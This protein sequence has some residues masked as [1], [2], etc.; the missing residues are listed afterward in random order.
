[1]TDYPEL[2]F[3]FFLL[4]A[5]FTI[6]FTSCNRA[7]EDSADRYVVMVSLDGFRYDYPDLYATPVL[8]SVEKAGVRAVSLQPS[9]P[10]KT[11]PNHYTIATGLYPDHHG[12]VLNNFF[13]PESG[14]TY[15]IGNRQRVEDPYFY[16][17]EPVWVT[18]EKQGIKAAS[19]YWVGSETSVE[20]IY[21]TYWK[22][23]DHQFPY[24]QRIDTVIAWL[25][26]PP[27]KRPHLITWY[28]DQPD[29]WGHHTGPENPEIGPLISGLDSLLGYFF[30]K[31]RNLPV[32]HETDVIITSDHG[33][34]TISGNRWVNLTDYLNPEWFSHITGSNP[35]WDLWI[36]KEYD[37]LA[38]VKV[39]SI[40]H[41]QV[42]K[43][44]EVPER[45]HYGTNPRCGDLVIA[46]DSNWSISWKNPG[47]G[48]SGGTHG[49]DNTNKN[50]HAIF[51][52][53]GPDFK[54]GYS[55]PVFENVDIYPLI[56]YLLDLIPAANDG[57]PERVFGMLKEEGGRMNGEG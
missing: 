52:A 37:S 15:S 45:L 8:D 21:P 44:G 55:Q 25:Q 12:I 2:T 39:A 3:S 4:I 33:M 14:M 48:F 50:M 51:Y 36:H 9:F 29:G 10:T 23:Y 5:L 26:L 49:Y 43:S 54:K 27:E 30:N 1:M 11:F 35:V 41:V 17:G 42:W 47:P 24:T 31:L 57:K 20:G 38:Y 28:I 7:P 18:A 34:E 32:Y 56:C 40:P 13:D 19:F 46:A 53:C 16:S 6:L 22:K